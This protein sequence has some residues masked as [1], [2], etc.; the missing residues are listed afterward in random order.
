MCG[1]CL[2]NR[3]GQRV[4]SR[5]IVGYG[6][7]NI[8]NAQAERTA[9]GGKQLRRRLFVTTLDLGKIAKR[10]PRGGRHVAQGAVLL[11]PLRAEHGTEMAAQQSHR[12]A[13]HKSVVVRMRLGYLQGATCTAHTRAFAHGEHPS[14]RSGGV[15]DRRVTKDVQPQQV[16][17]GDRSE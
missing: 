5:E 1:H 10:D 14:N 13:R 12:R 9:D 3:H 15:L 7:Q 2:E 11:L 17:R 8:G 4:R 6:V 16:H